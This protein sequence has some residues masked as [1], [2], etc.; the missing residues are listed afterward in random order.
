MN[1]RTTVG[2]GKSKE[3]QD[4][5]TCEGRTKP[6]TGQSVETNT[7]SNKQCHARTNRNQLASVH[8]PPFTEN[9]TMIRGLLTC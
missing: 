2:I 3:E 1:N 6:S 9:T 5:D 7:R 4:K 8:H